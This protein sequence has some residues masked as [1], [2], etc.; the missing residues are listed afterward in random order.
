MTRGEKGSYGRGRLSV[1]KGYIQPRSRR[2]MNWIGLGGAAAFVL[3]FAFSLLARSGEFASG[4]PLSSAHANF[5][6]DC[7]ACHRTLMQKAGDRTLATGGAEDL[8]CMQCHG[9]P[10]EAL[11][12][13]SFAR[14]Y[15]YVSGDSAG[16]AEAIAGHSETPC[17]SCHPEHRGHDAVIIDVP[18]SRC[19]RC[20]DY[21]SF[22]RNHPQFDFL[23][24][25]QP[26][27]SSLIFTHV[28]HSQEVQ[29]AF[30]L[31]EP[32][33]YCHQLE[34]DGRTFKPIRFED[35]CQFC[36]LNGAQGMAGMPVKDPKNPES[37]GAETLE[38]I[39]DR[40]DPGTLWAHLAN[41]NEFSGTRKTVAAGAEAGAA[42]SW[43]PRT[44]PAAPS[45]KAA[46]HGLMTCVRE[47]IRI[48]SSAIVFSIA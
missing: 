17:A 12:T 19:I 45:A 27:D 2:L 46:S 34:A 44:W 13:Y 6:A 22:T 47:L 33:E 23:A 39:K 4:G 11:G 32:C 7:D 9:G 37:V 28:R 18:D 14:H 26:D 16:L 15:V 36:H 41:P 20:H 35:H 10:G 38:M 31:G 48:F 1:S 29:K 43:T 3:Y 42:P 21:G 30:A 24:E 40:G 25:N 8:N 5:E